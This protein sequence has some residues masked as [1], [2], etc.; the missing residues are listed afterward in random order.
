MKN[1][2]FAIVTTLGF[3]SVAHA[4]NALTAEQLLKSVQLAVQ[5][6]SATDPDMFKSI[7]GLRTATVGDNAQVTVDMK[8]DGMNMSVKYL[9]VPQGQ[10]MVCRQHQ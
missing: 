8:A 9:C 7:S 4:D 2:L 3:V 6:Q 10:N 1:V 5:D